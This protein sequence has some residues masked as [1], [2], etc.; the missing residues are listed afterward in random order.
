MRLLLLILSAIALG[1]AQQ[2]F[3]TD[4]VD[5][6]PVRHFHLEL[7]TEHD[8]LQNTSY[9]ALRQNTSRLQLTYGL[10]KDLEIGID[11]PLLSIYNA[12][13]SGTADAVGLGD[14]NL[15]MKLRLRREHEGS[16]LPAMTVALYVELPTGN[17]RN[18]L[19][20]GVADYWLNG[21]AQKKLT[22][23]ITYRF[24]SGI[25]FSGNTLTGAIG[26]RSNR[27][28]VF[29]GAS[30]LTFNVTERWLIGG[31]IAG[32]LTLEFDLGKGQLQSLLGAKCAL[33]KSI[34]LDFAITGGKFEGAPRLGGSVGISVDF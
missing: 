10:S 24:N 17:P 5:V 18:Q 7:L 21:I 2:P 1:K 13:E 19:G 33:S 32:A 26:I 8:R 29:T 12:A 3:L 30:S 11:G 4:D 6:A 25:L 20:S 9:P 16:R 22:S 27:G 15:Q 31:E 14:L 34:G 28:V 23:R